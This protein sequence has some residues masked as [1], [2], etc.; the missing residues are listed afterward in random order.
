MPTAT[1]CDLDY[2]EITGAS[3][4][5]GEVEIRGAKNAI[6]KLLVASIISNH[7]YTFYNVPN[8][9]EVDITLK[10]C[11]SVGMLAQW[12]RKA[13]TIHC[14]TKHITSTTIPTSFSGANRLPILML[15]ALLT[16]TQEMITIPALGGCKIGKRSIDFHLAALRQLGAEI[17]ESRTEEG[18]IYQASTKKALVGTTIT[19]PYPSVMA[20]ENAILA[21]T[22]AKGETVIENAAI[23]PEII[24]L[25][26]FLQKIGV[27]IT[28][29]ADRTIVIEHTTYFYPADHH[30]VTDRIE[31][32]SYGMAAIATKGRVFVKG[33][34]QIDMIAFLNALRASGGQFTVTP[35][36]IEFFYDTPLK[37][38]ILV[39]TNVHPG[40]LTDW[41]QPFAI[42]LTQA[43]ESSIIHETVYENRFGYI[44]ALKS[45]GV[46]AD[47][48]SH[49]LGPN[50]C[51]FHGKEH[52]HSL[53]VKPGALLKGSDIHIPDLRAGFAYVLAALIAPE[54]SRLFG[55]HYL[56]RGYECVAT[57]LTS[58]GAKCKKI[59]HQKQKI[60]AIA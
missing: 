22:H 33:A 16:R 41:Q 29:K 40:F 43:K 11:Q 4:L 15:G 59:S 31:A 51:R 34:R 13:G 10:L 24:D 32:A 44:E 49:C 53:V 58:L 56:D 23:E 47:L 17:E 38:G 5:Q 1:Q 21:A 12:D 52:K 18:L 46:E 8:I 37:G 7:P 35:E 28:V 20:T 57:K 3:P 25:I 9:K 48:F 14:Q 26:L 30:V 19:L 36:G 42:L 6:S 45:M 50:T 39:E 54:T 27:I 55:L 2:L 60:K